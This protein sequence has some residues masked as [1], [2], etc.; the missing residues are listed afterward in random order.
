[1]TTLN[2]EAGNEACAD[3]NLR[4]Q[5]GRNHTAR[6]IDIAA[7]QNFPIVLGRL[8]QLQAAFKRSPR[9]GFAMEFGVFT[10]GS[11]RTLAVGNK[12]SRFIG[13][14]SF[15][16]L[17]EAWHRSETSIYPAGHFKMKSLPL[18]PS[19]VSLIEGFIEDTLP[20]WLEK[21][22][23][24]VSFVHIDVDL[25]S[26]AKFILMALSDRL[27]EGAVIVFDELCDWREQGIY[28]LWREG[29]WKAL[30]EWL[31]ATGF[32]C[33]ILSRGER[34]EAAI[35]V[36]RRK[37]A[38]RSSSAEM[39]HASDL[40]ACGLQNE[41]I[42]LLSDAVANKPQWMG[43][44]HRL[45][46]WHTKMRNSS[47]ALTLVEKMQPLALASPDHPHSID[48]YKLSAENY[49]R[50]GE[51]DRAWKQISLFREKRP[52]HV[53]GLALFGRIAGRRHDHE[54]SAQAWGL[55][56][57]LSGI[58]EYRQNE[59]DEKV[60]SEITP[61]FRS[62][63]FSGLM[64]QHLIEQRD[65]STVLDIGSGSGEQAAALRA[66]GKIVTELDYGESYYFTK[67]SDG[68]SVIIGDFMNI[69]F[70]QVYDCVIASHILEH[71]LNVN[72]FLKKLH[73]VVKE[74]GLV[75]ISV[76]PM[77]PNIVGGH[78]TLWNAGLVLYNLV[79]A[80]F[81]C[82]EPWIR[83]YGYNISVVLAKKTISAQGL[84]YDSGDIDRIARYLP[85]GFHEGFD[86]NI[87]RLG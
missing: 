61:P 74:G 54:A 39:Q 50:L 57:S 60:L 26:A 1:M 41:A 78:V 33:R 49:F 2:I 3:Y 12:D 44:L 5:L 66:H 34:F 80:G 10:G 37:P 22:P 42:A 11:L 69:D 86:G 68:G 40:W 47:E 25:Y 29:E 17:P 30:N 70:P 72:S 21:N 59:E 82:R 19:N 84:A 53:G 20:P 16:G 18:M 65:F 46:T 4:E 58:T 81:D 9:T 38:S 79:L 63:K 85:E 75:A 27:D 56:Y 32:Y 36:Y 43:G 73:S 83:A 35:Q 62:M 7:F 51:L 71:Q 77:K 76:P 67:N 6:N 52:G 8:L 14:D 48:L 64:I 13:F 23:G 28:T 87:R 24:K 15:K 55:A 45:L 31:G